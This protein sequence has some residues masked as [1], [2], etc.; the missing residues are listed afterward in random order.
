MSNAHLACRWLSHPRVLA[1]IFPEEASNEP[2]GR[3]KDLR[4]AIF[5]GWGMRS[6]KHLKQQTTAHKVCCI[7]KNVNFMFY[8]R[9]T[10]VTA[11]AVWQ[12]ASAFLESNETRKAPQLVQEHNEWKKKMSKMRPSSLEEAQA[13]TSF[14]DDDEGGED[15]GGEDEGARTNPWKICFD[16]LLQSEDPQAL[17]PEEGLEAVQKH[18]DAG[19]CSAR[20]RSSTST[21]TS[22]VNCVGAGVAAIERLFGRWGHLPLKL[23]GC[24][25]EEPQSFTRG[26]SVGQRVARECRSEWA[27]LTP[28]AK[29]NDPV[30][31][32]LFEGEL[33]ACGACGAGDGCLWGRQALECTVQ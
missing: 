16:L 33:G 14:W 25:V 28:E 27:S 24:A 1:W 3:C 21:H 22:W 17:S 18:I 2:Q 11:Q 31:R 7:L 13:A 8:S 12:P 30:S 6:M 23:A 9:V 29:A 15:E 4:K 19:A 10:L 32:E 26:G 5:K 20:L